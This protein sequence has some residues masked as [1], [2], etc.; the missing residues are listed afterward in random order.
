MRSLC[1]KATGASLRNVPNAGRV[2]LG[3]ETDA[4]VT[5]QRPDMQALESRKIG[6]KDCEGLL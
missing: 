5:Q 2:R 4:R 1:K 3:Y 6:G